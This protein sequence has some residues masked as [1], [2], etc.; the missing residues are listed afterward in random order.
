MIIRRLRDPESSIHIGTNFIIIIIIII[1]L[2]LFCCYYY[3]YYFYYLYR[4][5]RH[6]YKYMLPIAGQTAGPIGLNFFYYYRL[7]EIRKILFLIF[8]HGQRRALQLVII[9]MGMGMAAVLR[10]RIRWIRNILLPGSG[11]AK[12]STDP[13]P[14]F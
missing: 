7:K 5:T 8:F 2:L 12:R 4:K 3:D 6:L 9:C 13:N 10:I 11:Y 14:D 1:I